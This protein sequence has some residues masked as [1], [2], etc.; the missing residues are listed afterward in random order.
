M[1][2]EIGVGVADDG[3]PD[4]A[5]LAAL[6]SPDPPPDAAN[7]VL[8]AEPKEFTIVVA[9]TIGVGVAPPEASVLDAK[10]VP[11]E[12]IMTL[13]VENIEVEVT[14]PPLPGPPDAPPLP[15]PEIPPAVE[16]G[17]PLALPEAAPPVS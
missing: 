17:I 4:A 6:P 2:I 9:E 3:A 13:S 11:P 15:P 5:P 1:I 12:M 8:K 16:P 10:A 14:G 7:P